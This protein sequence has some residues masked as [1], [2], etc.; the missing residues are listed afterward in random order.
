MQQQ[1]FQTQ[2]AR[3]LRSE[4]TP[5]EKRLWSHLRGRHFTGFKFR[6]QTPLVGYIVDFFCAKARLIVELDG[7]SHLGKE[8]RDEQRT[9]ALEH[10]G[11]KVLRFWDTSVYDDFDAVLELIWRECR[12]RVES[13]SPPTPLPR[14]ERGARQKNPSPGK[15]GE[16]I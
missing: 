3:E 4:M 7:E 16:T 14:G 11:F 12:A 8:G 15:P 13:P 6:R 10:A 2:R 5:T 9:T 1:P